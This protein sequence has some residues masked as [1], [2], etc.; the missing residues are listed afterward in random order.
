MQTSSQLDIA[1][2][3]LGGDQDSIRP[4]SPT[5]TL[6]FL[7]GPRLGG[8]DK[9]PQLQGEGVSPARTSCWRQGTAV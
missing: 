1:R 7:Q 4:A 8:A 2:L 6:I 9:T 5:N 3:L